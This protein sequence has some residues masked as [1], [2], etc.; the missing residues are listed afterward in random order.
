M[1]LLGPSCNCKTKLP[2]VV[3][4][5]AATCCTFLMICWAVAELTVEAADAS[6]PPLARLT[7]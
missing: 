4:D 7:A 6:S 2:P 5:A 3:P 1:N